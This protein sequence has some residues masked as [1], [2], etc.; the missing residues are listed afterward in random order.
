VPTA[1]PG[2]DSKEKELERLMDTLRLELRLKDA[3]N[4]FLQAELEKK[5]T[6]MDVLTEGLKEVEVAQETWL[7]N[8]EDLTVDLESAIRV[9]DELTADNTRLRQENNLALD[10]LQE[11]EQ[12]GAENLRLRESLNALERARERDALKFSALDVELDSLK[13]RL[14]QVEAERDAARGIVRTN[15][16]I[17]EGNNA[18]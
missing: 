3:D 17:F 6:L 4:K 11:T 16:A 7:R 8:N 1:S 2:A 9:I 5:E 18:K 12:L 15:V 14:Q 13:Q 10:V